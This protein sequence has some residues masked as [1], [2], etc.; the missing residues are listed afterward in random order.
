MSC[1]LLIFY[2]HLSVCFLSYLCLFLSSCAFWDFAQKP[3]PYITFII[4]G[5]RG[6]LLFKKE[7]LRTHEPVGVLTKRV[8]TE[9][10][11]KGN[12]QEICKLEGVTELMGIGPLQVGEDSKNFRSYGWCY[13]V[14]GKLHEV[15]PMSFYADNIFHELLWAYSFSE[16]KNGQWV[17]QC[18]RDDQ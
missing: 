3:S 6:E 5:R 17:S 11:V 13:F 8:L 18:I 4:K 12:Y 2:R 9:S 16:I 7:I 15:A 10:D 1:K 14:D